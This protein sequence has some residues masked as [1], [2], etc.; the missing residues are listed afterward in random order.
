MFTHTTRGSPG[1]DTKRYPGGVLRQLG[2]SCLYFAI[3]LLVF[4]VYLQIYI[5]IYV[6]G[7]FFCS[8]IFGWAGGWVGK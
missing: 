4:Y 3:L 2:R 6:T 5:Y 1:M 8:S 7:T